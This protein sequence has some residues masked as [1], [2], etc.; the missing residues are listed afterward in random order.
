MDGGA[1]MSDT[2]FGQN[3][4]TYRTVGDYQLPNLA[5][6]DASKSHIGIWGQRRLEYLR[7][8]KRVLYINL[9]TS[10]KLY[11]HLSE[12]DATAIER[13]ETIVRQ[14]AAAQGIT[15]QLKAKNQMLWVGKMNN[16]LACADEILQNELIYN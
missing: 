12:I 14:M 13:Q 11:E 8:H 2:T 15:E 5:V 16:I 10:G 4:G 6:P 1:G 7:E 9:L 3:G